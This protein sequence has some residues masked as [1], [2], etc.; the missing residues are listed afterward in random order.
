MTF[1][2]R[3][4]HIAP[5]VHA[6]ARRSAGAEREAQRLPRP[7]AGETAGLLRQV[8]ER[9]LQRREPQSEAARFHEG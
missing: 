9:T 6:P 1:P 7:P 8:G 3:P 4:I 5:S 2:E